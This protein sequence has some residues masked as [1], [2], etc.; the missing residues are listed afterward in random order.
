MLQ[1]SIQVLGTTNEKKDLLSACV[2]TVHPFHKAL[3]FSTFLF[4]LCQLYF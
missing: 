3:S 1:N 2:I 4:L